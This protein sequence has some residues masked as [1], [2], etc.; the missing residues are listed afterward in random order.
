MAHLSLRTS[1]HSSTVSF[2]VR[3][4]SVDWSHLAEVTALHLVTTS[5]FCSRLHYLFVLCSDVPPSGCGALGRDFSLCPSLIWYSPSSTTLHGVKA[6]PSFLWI[7]LNSLQ[8]RSISTSSYLWNFL[9]VSASPFTLHRVLRVKCLKPP[10]FDAGVTMGGAPSKQKPRFADLIFAWASFSKCFVTC[11]Q[12][13]MFSSCIVVLQ[14]DH[15]HLPH[16]DYMPVTFLILLHH[17]LRK[18]VATWLPLSNKPVSCIKIGPNCRAHLQCTLWSHFPSSYPL[19]IPTSK[20]VLQTRFPTVR[21]VVTLPSR[22]ENDRSHVKK[23]ICGFAFLL[24]LPRTLY[25]YKIRYLI[26]N[27]VLLLHLVLL[28]SCSVSHQRSFF[29]VANNYPAARNLRFVFSSPPP[30]MSSHP[31]N[32]HLEP[33][34]IFGFGLSSMNDAS[35]LTTKNS[36]LPGRIFAPCLPR[37]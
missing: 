26:S 37:P 28:E 17:L 3:T 31:P 2:S 21:R 34:W 23:A 11:A 22:V 18:Y 19:F 36:G 5:L 1:S 15:P 33:T 12:F 13:N 6:V 16:G 4:W 10:T 32:N 20:F 27:N 35:A 25:T 24:L 29:M 14:Q 9:L 7:Q 8:V 30:S